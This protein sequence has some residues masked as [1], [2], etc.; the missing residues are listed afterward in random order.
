MRLEGNNQLQGG[1]SN[2]VAYTYTVVIQTAILYS[3]E[4]QTQN[5]Q[6]NSYVTT[7]FSIHMLVLQRSRIDAR[8]L[9][10]VVAKQDQM[11]ATYQASK[12]STSCNDSCSIVTAGYYLPMM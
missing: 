5:K 10:V 7:W 11:V 12:F 4:I 8:V 2:S 9:T 6:V 1:N 3:H